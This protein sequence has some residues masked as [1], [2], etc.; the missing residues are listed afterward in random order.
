[1]HGLVTSSGTIYIRG[2]DN[3]LEVGEAEDHA[4]EI[5][6]LPHPLLHDHTLIMF[7]KKSGGGALVT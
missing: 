3:L 2:V 6:S 4:R 5:F 1:M 7:D